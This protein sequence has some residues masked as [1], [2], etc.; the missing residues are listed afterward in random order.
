MRYAAFDTA[1]SYRAATRDREHVFHRHQERFVRRAFRRR[2]VTVYFIHQLYDLLLVFRIPFQRFQRGTYHDG[3]IISRI[4]VAA[5]KVAHFHLYQ[6]DQF[7]IVYHVGFVQEHYHRRYA[8]LT[9]QQDVFPGLRHRTVRRAYYQDRAV[10]LRRAGDHVLNI[11]SMPRAVYVRIVTVLRLIF[12]VRG[13]DR[14]TAFSFFR[15]FIDHV[16]IHEFRFAFSCQH[17]R[18]RGR[19][20]GFAMVYVTD[21]TDVYMRFASFKMCLCHFKILPCDLINSRIVSFGKE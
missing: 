7:R 3:N 19:Q 14:D 13:V 21:G 6:L 11:V 16:V 5:Q 8:Y 15:R 12:Y 17:F 20:R 1:R 9:R 10:H 18:D 2:D 4:F